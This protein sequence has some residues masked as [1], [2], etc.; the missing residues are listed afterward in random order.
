M[1]AELDNC[2]EVIFN[3]NVMISEEVWRSENELIAETEWQC[4]MQAVQC[5]A[6]HQ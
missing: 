2:L 5:V 3:V 1:L 4:V 6:E